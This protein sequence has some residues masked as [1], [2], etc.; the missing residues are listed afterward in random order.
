VIIFV[1]KAYCAK[2]RKQN[3]YATRYVKVAWRWLAEQD[4]SSVTAITSDA[5]TEPA[6]KDWRG[7]VTR[8]LGNESMWPRWAGNAPGSPSCKCPPEILAEFSV[9]PNTGRRI[10]GT[11]YFAEIETPEL[12]ANVSFAAEH[13]LKI[14][15][16]DYTSDGV[17]KTGAFFMKRI[18]PGYDEATGEKLPPGAEDA[19]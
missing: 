6:E 13:R 18:P 5:P 8:W 10:D 17:T 19:A 1:A 15:L 16:Y 2:V 9:C 7:A 14:K 4:F 12:A 11:W 3:N